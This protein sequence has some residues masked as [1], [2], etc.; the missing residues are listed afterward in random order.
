MHL[1][2]HQ[3]PL[4]Y[5]IALSTQALPSGDVPELMNATG[6]GSYKVEASDSQLRGT[7]AVSMVPMGRGGNSSWELVL[8]CLAIIFQ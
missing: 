3:G 8:K 1:S 2:G 6:E 5:I 7:M 4:W